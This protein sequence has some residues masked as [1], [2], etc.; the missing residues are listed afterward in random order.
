ML[1]TVC[2]QSLETDGRVYN[3]W[4]QFKKSII[5]FLWRRIICFEDDI[6]YI[7]RLSSN[8]KLWDKLQTTVKKERHR[9]WE[10]CHK[11]TVGEVGIGLFSIYV[12][13]LFC[14]QSLNF[15]WNISHIFT[16]QVLAKK[17]TSGP[18]Y[19]QYIL[20]QVNQGNDYFH[21]SLVNKNKVINCYVRD[22]VNLCLH[23]LAIFFHSISKLKIYSSELLQTFL[24]FLFFGGG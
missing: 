21:I 8:S 3:R 9:R 24:F 15:P 6:S 10:E 12:V 18:K 16:V 22:H 13:F 5:R 4:W 11:F 14:M 17:V 2:S 20:Y 1:D 23:V 7:F 19:F